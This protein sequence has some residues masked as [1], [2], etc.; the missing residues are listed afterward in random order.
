M[1]DILSSCGAPLFL[2]IL[3]VTIP[4]S[5]IIFLGLSR[6]LEASSDHLG[7]LGTGKWQDPRIFMSPSHV[8]CQVGRWVIFRVQE[9]NL[10]F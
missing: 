9:L 4:S 6:P 2:F 8:S 7:K 5:P 1:L 10:G 3:Y